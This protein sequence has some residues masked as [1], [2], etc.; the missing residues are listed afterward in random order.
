M[1]GNGISTSFGFASTYS[2]SNGV[3]LQGIATNGTQTNTNLSYYSFGAGSNVTD[4]NSSAGGGFGDSANKVIVEDTG[5]LIYSGSGTATLSRAYTFIGRT[6][7]TRTQL[8]LANPLGLI[9]LNGTVELSGT[10]SD[11]VLFTGGNDPRS[12]IR[13]SGTLIG[14]ANLDCGGWGSMTT[15][16]TAIIGPALNSSGWT[17]KLSVNHIDY[18][19]DITNEITYDNTTTVNIDNI[20]AGSLTVN[21]AQYTRASGSSMTYIGSTGQN[22]TLATGNWVSAPGTWIT[23]AGT[24]TL[25]LNLNS[26][27]ITVLRA[28]V[29]GRLNL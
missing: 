4:A 3:R 25:N 11:Y 9:D 27:Q 12:R 23:T 1:N 18:A 29:L 10:A 2:V 14:N 6:R 26:F 13:L 20:T 24:L 17:G 5:A 15:D 19:A 16:A 28:R 7:S 21:H 22:L 8:R